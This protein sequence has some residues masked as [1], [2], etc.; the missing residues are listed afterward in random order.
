MAMCNEFGIFP[1]VRGFNGKLMVQKEVTFPSEEDAKRA[2]QIFA[3]ILGGAVAFRRANDPD[4]GIVGQ[5]II[6]GKYGLMAGATASPNEV[7]TRRHDRQDQRGDGR[8]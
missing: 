8:A 4:A 2:G 5:G 6:I 1:V 7:V 3:D